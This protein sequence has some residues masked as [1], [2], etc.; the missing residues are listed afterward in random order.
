MLARKR[1]L[2][3]LAHGDDASGKRFILVPIGPKPGDAM[4]VGDLSGPE[5]CVTD[6]T[7]HMGYT[8]IPSALPVDPSSGDHGPLGPGKLRGG[9]ATTPSR[10]HNRTQCTFLTLGSRNVWS[11]P[12][13]TRVFSTRKHG[14]VYS[15]TAV[16]SGWN[17]LAHTQ[18]STASSLPSR[19]L[20]DSLYSRN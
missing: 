6:R 3:I 13:G 4:A 1:R 12:K 5:T 14:V 20:L 9:F 11:A 19:R 10:V 17:A 18:S 8:L 16:P 2:Y 15:L 7:G